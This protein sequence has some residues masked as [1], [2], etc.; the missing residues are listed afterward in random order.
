M[1][2][3]STETYIVELCNTLHSVCIGSP[4]RLPRSKRRLSEILDLE[5]ETESDTETTNQ[6]IKLRKDLQI[7]LDFENVL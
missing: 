3:P 5:D 4:V 2:E 6:I 7:E 1:A